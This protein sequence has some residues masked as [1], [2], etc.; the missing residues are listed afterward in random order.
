MGETSENIFDN[1]WIAHYTE[2]ADNLIKEY[3]RAKSHG[4]IGGM[5]CALEA[6]K[7]HG[8]HLRA[9]KSK[10]DNGKGDQRNR[11]GWNPPQPSPLP[12]E[13]V[14]KEEVT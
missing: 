3:L 7:L 14:R 10:I 5:S 6:M 8:T 1:P 13:A 9:R 2:E 4:D 12:P 11:S